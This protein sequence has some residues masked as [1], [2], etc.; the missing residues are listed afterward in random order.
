MSK[1]ELVPPAKGLLRLTWPQV[2][3]LASLWLYS[4]AEGAALHLLVVIRNGKPVKLGLPLALRQAQA[5]A[6]GLARA[7]K[8]LIQSIWKQI[9]VLDAKISSLCAY[10]E[11]TG[12]ELALPA[13]VTAGVIEIGQPAIFEKFRPGRD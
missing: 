12:A 1:A 10:S 8:E 9:A 3:E 4:Q 6:E 7:G 2:E 11:T 13:V 5:A